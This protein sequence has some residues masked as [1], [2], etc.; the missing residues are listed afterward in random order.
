MNTLHVAYHILQ[1]GVCLTVILLSLGLA[2]CESE[3]QSP[4]STS[5]LGCPADWLDAQPEGLGKLET[6]P[7]WANVS[8]AQYFDK[9]SLQTQFFL[10]VR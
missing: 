6:P 2:A 4:L 10:A 5:S 8:T 9:T 3:D 7:S 1:V